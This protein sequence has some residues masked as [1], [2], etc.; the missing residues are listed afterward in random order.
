MALSCKCPAL[1][2]GAIPT[3]DFLLYDFGRAGKFRAVKTHVG[4]VPEHF[5][6]LNGTNQHK[7][8]T[9]QIDCAI[10]L[11]SFRVLDHAAGAAPCQRVHTADSRLFR[12]TTEILA[13]DLRPGGRPTVLARRKTYV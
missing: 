6:P 3:V 11:G 8:I 2:P 1:V 7:L 4:V 10:S 13:C 12:H 5:L 9:P